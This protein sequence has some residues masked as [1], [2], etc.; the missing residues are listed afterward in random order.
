MKLL[1]ALSVFATLSTS[2]FAHPGT[3]RLVCK[4]A[5]NSGSTQNVEVHVTRF[6]STGWSNPTIELTLGN[7]KFELTTPD[8]MDNYGETIHDS[9]LKVIRVTGAVPYEKDNNNGYFSVTAKPETV[10]A[11]DLDGNPVQWSLEAEKDDCYDS[12]GSST[13]QAIIKGLIYSNEKLQLIDT[14][15]LDCEL[16]Y[17]S[18]MAC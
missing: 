6:N 10:K 5:A 1:I 12:N 2:A 4:S 7:N 17:N 16:T 14:Q 18:G 15:V 8:E 9:P 11:F 3:N 13:F